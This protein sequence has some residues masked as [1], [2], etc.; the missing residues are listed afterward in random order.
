MGQMV[1]HINLIPIS[2]TDPFRVPFGGIDFC[3]DT[4]FTNALKYD[5]LRNRRNVLQ[6][7]SYFIGLILLLIL[8]IEAR[9][10]FCKVSIL[11]K[12]V[13]QTRPLPQTFEKEIAAALKVFIVLRLR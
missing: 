6:K 1:G 2:P 9:V 3:P 10:A 8:P 11:G 4:G 13:W 5:I 12:Y 7:N